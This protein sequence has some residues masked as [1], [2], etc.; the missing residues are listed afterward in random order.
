M[1]DSQSD[2]PG[3]MAYVALVASLL[4]CSCFPC[5]GSIVGVVVGKMEL[6][7][8]SRGESPPAGA[9]LAKIGIGIGIGGILLGL[10]CTVIGIVWGVFLGGLEAMF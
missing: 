7:K 1:E 2:R 4:G 6:D 9:T 5:F 8:I 3:Q 10:L